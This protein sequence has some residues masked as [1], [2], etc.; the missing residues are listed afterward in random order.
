M[1]DLSY[2]SIGLG[3][4]LLMVVPVFIFYRREIAF[5]IRRL[6]GIADAKDS[7]DTEC[8]DAMT[9]TDSSSRTARSTLST[10]IAFFGMGTGILSIIIGSLVGSIFAIVSG[11]ILI[12]ALFFSFVLRRTIRG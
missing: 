10:T 6:L 11:V 12:S 7:V 3:L 1:S 9:R 2:F 5:N 8:S 4:G